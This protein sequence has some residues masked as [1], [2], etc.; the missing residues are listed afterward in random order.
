[1]TKTRRHALAVA[2]RHRSSTAHRSP[3]GHDR[4]IRTEGSAF[5]CRSSARD[6]GSH[7]DG[8]GTA[9]IDRL[10]VRSMKRE[11]RLGTRGEPWPQDPGP[12]RVP[13]VAGVVRARVGSH[14]CPHGAGQGSALAT[15]FKSTSTETVVETQPAADRGSASGYPGPRPTFAVR[16]RTHSRPGCG[17]ASSGPSQ[18]HPP[19][20]PTSDL[21]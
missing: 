13:A 5:G 14:R 21:E 16:P 6:H 15:V 4:Y 10:E 8:G 2:L 7:L 12:S 17:T 20:P 9:S 11:T 19:C 18:P 1:V 3:S